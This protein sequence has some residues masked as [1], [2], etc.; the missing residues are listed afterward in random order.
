MI[1][2]QPAPNLRRYAQVDTGPFRFGAQYT[3]KTADTRTFNE[4]MR[5]ARPQY[6]WSAKHFQLMHAALDRL[7]SG[8][9]T[10]L[11]Y[12]ISA[13]HGK[14]ESLISFAT[15]TLELAPATE[16]VVASYNQDQANELSGKIR[17]MAAERGVG[18]RGDKD[19][20]KRW[21]TSAGGGIKA[22]G[23]GG[24]L[25]SVN[26]GLVIVD[27]PIGSRFDAESQ[28]TRDKIW[29]WLTDD[30]LAR[31]TMKTRIVISHPR[32]HVD[33]IIGRLRERQ[34]ERWHIIDL[35]GRAEANDPLGRA[36]DEPLWPAERGEDW[37][38][39][40]RAEVGEYGYASLCLG[41]PRPREGG[42]FKTACIG[43]METFP[44]QGELVRYWDLAGTQPKGRNHDPD[45]TAGAL[46][47]RMTDQSTAAFNVA[48]FRKGVYERDV[49]L[50]NVCAA[51]L[52]KH[53][54]R[55]RWWIEA[56]AGI[57]GEQRTSTL[58]RELQA[59]G[60]PVYTEHP[61]GSKIIRAEPFASAV[62]AR[63]VFLCPESGEKWHDA[64][65][66]ELADFPN[67][68]HD[69]QVDAASG[70]FNKLAVPIRTISF[71][72]VSA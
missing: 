9:I 27:D 14:T 55:I 52:Q 46:L 5:H 41:R 35:P 17:D 2:T 58:V 3:P 56:E 44:A 57:A 60:M 62:G 42:M 67:G 32:W 18:V 31:A 63:N 72:S 59:M 69:D 29:G 24:K 11:M 13:R 6:D 65:L 25:A 61:T 33:D 51:D 1:A 15:R 71:G 22:V 40:Y 4:W 8:E 70:A 20:V 48:R 26:A 36:I 23:V 50:R 19:A 45:F 16:I 10:R 34:G 68:R 38:E 39:M 54:G 53:R 66:G 37:H 21:K 47:C 12:Q 43:K 30:V 49:E 28:V 64:F 7:S